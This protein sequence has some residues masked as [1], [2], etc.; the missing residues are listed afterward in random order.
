M[1]RDRAPTFV[2]PERVLGQKSQNLT[3]WLIRGYVTKAEKGLGQKSKS[4]N[5]NN[6]HESE[7][8]RPTV[9]TDPTVLQLCSLFL[10]KQSSIRALARKFLN[11][12]SSGR[13]LATARRRLVLC[14]SILILGCSAGT[15]KEYYSYRLEKFR[16]VTDRS[17]AAV[18][19]PRELTP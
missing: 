16:A 19:D 5:H 4:F 7:R 3:R 14:F 6:L 18:R 17:P 15:R 12:M 13:S 8:R 2:P 10:F 9:T 11:G 1:S